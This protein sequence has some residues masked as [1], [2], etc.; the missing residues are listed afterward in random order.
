MLSQETVTIVLQYHALQPSG[1]EARYPAWFN[2]S[3]VQKFKV[4]MGPF[5]R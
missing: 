2:S 3:K 5:N 1:T 4:G